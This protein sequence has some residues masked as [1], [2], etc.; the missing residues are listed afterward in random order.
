MEKEERNKIC[1][2]NTELVMGNAIGK[3]FVEK[4]FNGNSKESAKELI[5]NIKQAMLNRIP[6]MSW[7]DQA[8]ADYAIEK[9]NKM[10]YEKIGY[11]DY[12]LN[13]KELLEKD[14]EGLDIDSNTFF[15]TMLNNV[16]FSIK[17]NI[18]KID[19]PVDKDEWKMMPQVNF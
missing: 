15:N 13:P 10:T 3:Y 8:T 9:A 5:A 1:I 2:E 18:K 14:Y 19:E 12:I 11:A 6:E 4:A 7:L 17:K 16:I